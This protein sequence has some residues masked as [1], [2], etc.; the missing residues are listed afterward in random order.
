MPAETVLTTWKTTRITWI[1]SPILSSMEMERVGPIASL[2]EE[3]LLLENGSGIRSQHINRIL[4]SDDV[5]SL[6]Q[7]SDDELQNEGMLLIFFGCMMHQFINFLKLD[8]EYA[9]LCQCGHKSV[10][11]SRIGDHKTAIVQVDQLFRFRTQCRS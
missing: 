11:V 7:D 5:A 9:S 2:I 10:F 8:P 3:A 4:R 6:V 1:F